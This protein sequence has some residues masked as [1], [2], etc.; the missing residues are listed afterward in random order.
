MK[1]NVPL[2]L[3]FMLGYVGKLSKL[4]KKKLKNKKQIL[5]INLFN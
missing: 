5:K 4:K 3:H 2:G 1:N